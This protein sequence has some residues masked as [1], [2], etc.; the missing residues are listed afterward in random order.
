MNSPSGHGVIIS[1]DGVDYNEILDSKIHDNGNQWDGG[2]ANHGIYVHTSHNLIEGNDIHDNRFGYGI[3]LFD[4]LPMFNRILANWVHDNVDGMDIH[5]DG[6]LVALNLVWNQGI[7]IS[8]GPSG[9][10]LG[11]NK[12]FQNTMY[13]N[14]AGVHVR[15]SVLSAEIINNI[16]QASV[17]THK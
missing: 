8:L 3:H 10:V 1:G 14:E 17:V 7:G 16:V 9:S 13:R 6:N 2:S 5:G 12:I 4:G 15:D 11:R